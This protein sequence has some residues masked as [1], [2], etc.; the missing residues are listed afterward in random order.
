MSEEP[1]LAYP[2]YDDDPAVLASNAEKA[3]HD[4]ERSANFPLAVLAFILFFPLGLPALVA[5]ALCAMA[6]LAHNAGEAVRYSAYA[7]ITSIIGIIAGLLTLFV[8]FVLV[9]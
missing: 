5:S 6:A 7:R 3:S 4:R 2:V 9:K 8:W 1:K